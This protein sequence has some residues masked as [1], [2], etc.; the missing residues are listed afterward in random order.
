MK[1]SKIRIYSWLAENLYKLLETH[2]VEESL[3]KAK[4]MPGFYDK[5]IRWIN[6]EINN[7]NNELFIH[8]DDIDDDF[9]VI[10][11]LNTW[12][13]KRYW[14]T[15]NSKIEI[16]ELIIDCL[17]IEE[18]VK[19]FWDFQIPSDNIYDKSFIKKINESIFIKNCIVDYCKLHIKLQFLY[20]NFWNESLSI[21]SSDFYLIEIYLPVFF[22]LKN[23]KVKHL[24]IIGVS[25][26]QEIDISNVKVKKLEI[27]NWLLSTGEI[28][29]KIKLL[30]ISLAEISDFSI[31]SYNTER[32]EI[33]TFNLLSSSIGNG[34]LEKLKFDSI[35][36]QNLHLNNIY[37]A[38][39]IF[40]RD[41]NKFLIRYIRIKACSFINIDWWNYFRE[42]KDYNHAIWNKEMKELYRIFKYEHDLIWNK[43]EANKF[44]SKEMEYYRKSL[45][46]NY[47]WRTF[48]DIWIWQ[49]RVIC[50]YN[51]LTNDFWNSWIRPIL[52]MVLLVWVATFYEFLN[53]TGSFN[54]NTQILSN[55]L[56]I[57]EIWKFTTW[58]DFLYQIT[59]A[60]LIYQ[61]I[62][63]LRRISQR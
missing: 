20:S 15:D 19:F 41:K 53:S 40:P 11:L 44:F 51:Q 18:K 14:L 60:A 16:E 36:W 42:I 1:F 31:I 59:W 13:R 33:S 26:W 8:L 54:W 30:D 23:S 50:W 56:P 6:I 43:T 21:E 24:K 9:Y 62:I 27:A 52:I 2:N 49:K 47:G 35:C 57:S 4:S 17:G 38:D 32:I 37:F 12:L 46:D 22:H 5:K 25:L 7:T 29:N 10:D 48:F 3:V 55:I 63:A 28:I 61:F 34:F 39:I 45:L 58:F